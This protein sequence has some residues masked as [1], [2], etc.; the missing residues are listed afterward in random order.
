M[1]RVLAGALALCV[2]LPA[3]AAG[4]PAGDLLGPV[5]VGGIGG[6]GNAGDGADNGGAADRSGTPPNYRPPLHG[7]NPHGEGTV[8]TVDLN[9]SNSDPYPAGLSGGSED[10][11]VGDS[12]GESNGGAYH[13]RVTLIYVD[14]VLGLP[15][16]PISIETNPGET[17]HEPEPFASLNNTTLQQLCAGSGGN[18]CIAVLPMSSTTSSNSSS[19]SFALLRG[20]FF[21][22]QVLANI[23]TS[24]GEVYDAG[25]C[26]TANG[27]SSIANGSVAPGLLPGPLAGGGTFDVLSAS[28]SSTACSG[29]SSTQNSS[30]F[31]NAFGFAV[32]T[33]FLPG[34][35]NLVPNSS[36][37]AGPIGLVCHAN[38][39]NGGQATAPY[40]VREALTFF[41][42][43]PVLGLVKVT[44]SGPESRAIAPPQIQ[45]APGTRRSPNNKG[46]ANPGAGEGGAVAGEVASG[47]GGTL[48]LTGENLLLFG[49]IGTGLIGLGLVFM[50]ADRR[51]TA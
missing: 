12:R 8:A 31:I 1:M 32:P 45:T 13:G 43:V 22:G 6:G 38:D 44:V 3:A 7:T 29:G 11:V 50:A 24:N 35:A 46:P 41:A 25:G 36:L 40:G 49:L 26:Q 23:G 19:N 42:N 18:I 16:A 51:R 34:C 5:S 47:G 27:A 39:A 10:V 20:S 33:P 21:Q 4:D 37:T 15:I 9:P 30:S 17:R 28:S 48:P 14:P 2:F